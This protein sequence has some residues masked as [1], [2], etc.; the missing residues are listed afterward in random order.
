MSLDSFQIAIDK[1]PDLDLTAEIA[2]I[3]V[4]QSIDAP[5]RFRIRFPIDIAD[6]EVT[7]VDDDRLKP[8]DPDTEITVISVVNGESICLVHGV[9]TD[10]QISL[11]EGGPGSFLDVIG[12]DRRVVMD[13][14]HRFKA[15]EG[16]TSEIVEEIL[17]EYNFETDVD[18]PELEFEE[19]THTLNQTSSDLRFITELAGA[20]GARFWVDSEVSTSLFGGF[21][22]TETAHFKPSPPIPSDSGLG[23]S[24][25][26]PPLLSSSDTLELKLNQ[27][28]ETSNILRFEL[29][30]NSEAPTGSGEIQRISADDARANDS[31]VEST[32]EKL[33]EVEQ[34]GQTRTRQV[35]SAG[36]IEE[37]E[38]RNEAALNDASW[39]IQARARTTTHAIGGVVQVH[40]KVK[41]SGA[42]KLTDGEYF[43]RA[44]THMIDP[45]QHR[46]DIDL[47]RNA[48]GG[49]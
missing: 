29:M 19:D 1:E 37:A 27:G 5:T 31:E 25:P 38:L 6:G 42:G 10:R 21:E 2:E 4:Q 17:E 15:H 24:I 8:N 34:P 39:R 36:S 13:R 30:E 40:D 11:S 18:G 46:L 47:V 41:V 49:D 35:V 7:L 32:A 48:L 22:V 28:G 14:E 23:F 43:V 20:H 44:V 16:S 45:A 33:G 12:Q 9:I 3:E 26:L